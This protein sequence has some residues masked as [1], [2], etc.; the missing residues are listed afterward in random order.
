MA[1]LQA[2]HIREAAVLGRADDGAEATLFKAE[3][4]DALGLFAFFDATTAE[5]ALAGIADDARSDIIISG[6]GKFAFEL[7]RASTGELSDMEQFAMAV[8]HTGLA[9]FRVVGK[10]ELD[11]S[12]TSLRS[13]R[14]GNFDFESGFG[15]AIGNGEDAASDEAGATGGSDFDQANAAGSKAVMAMIPVAKG[16]DI[17]ASETT[18]FQDGHV[19]RDGIDASFDFYVNVFHDASLLIS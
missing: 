9:I 6:F 10:K 2:R 15:L 14:R 19:F 18:G 12:A 4:A 5:D 17:E 16:G 7:A 3:D 8:L 13:H 1:A 11:G